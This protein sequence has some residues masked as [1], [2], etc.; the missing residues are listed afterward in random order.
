M[1]GS[2]NSRAGHASTGWFQSAAGLL[3][4]SASEHCRADRFGPDV[5]DARRALCAGAT[6]LAALPTQLYI[7]SRVP[8]APVAAAR[9]LAE[10]VDDVFD[11]HQCVLRSTRICADMVPVGAGGRVAAGGLTADA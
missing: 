5:V 6:S 11:T 1:Y 9:L 8:D 4:F 3:G 10:L 7:S 2:T